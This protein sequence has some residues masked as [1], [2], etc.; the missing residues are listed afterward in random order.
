LKKRRLIVF[1]LAFVV[2]TTLIAQEAAEETAPQSEAE[3]VFDQGDDVQAEPDQIE[4][5]GSI[6]VWS[7]VSM[8]LVLAGVVA[9]I[10]GLFYL[11]KRM[12]GQ[13]YADN[14]LIKVLSTKSLSSTRAVH[15]VSLG[16]RYLLIGSAENSVNLLTE[17]DDK[18]SRDEIEVFLAK[19]EESPKRS[20]KEL[21]GGILPGGGSKVD[22]TVSSSALFLKSQGDRVKNL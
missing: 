1:A 11:L 7:F 22:E 10:Y 3:I 20:F 12:S 18:E 15:L 2:G 8:F 21:L 17:I 5:V 16:R 6:S 4:P 14:N 19:E 9:A 13:N